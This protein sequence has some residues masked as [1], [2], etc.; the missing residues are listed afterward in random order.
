LIDVDDLRRAEGRRRFL[1]EASTQ[2]SL[3]SVFNSRQLSI[4]RL[5]RSPTSPARCGSPIRKLLPPI[6]AVTAPERHLARLN[7][8]LLRHL[9]ERLLA[10]HRSQGNLC[11]K[12]D[13]GSSVFASPSYL[14]FDSH[15]GPLQADFT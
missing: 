15:A 13:D 6:P 8:E 9:G 4:R 1:S 7:L 2:K 5:N 11:L 10:L 14:L 3:P 12:A